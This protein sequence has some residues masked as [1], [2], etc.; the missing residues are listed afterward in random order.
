MTVGTEQLRAEVAA[1]AALR[2]EYCRSP[3][4]VTAQTFHVDH[5]VPQSKGGI[6]SLENLAY[7]CP[8]CNL[9]KKDVMTVIDPATNMAVD[10][11]HPR[12]HPWDEHFVWSADFLEI[13][14]RT[15]IGR[16]TVERL[17][18]N[19]EVL[20]RARAMWVQLKLIP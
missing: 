14:G 20:R 1:R 19:D 7:A 12:K 4:I 2:C 10:L 13:T 15:S 18:L 8:R 3:Q 17:Q 5:I 6:T 9:R 16:A 11:F